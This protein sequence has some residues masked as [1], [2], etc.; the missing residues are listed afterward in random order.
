MD[1]CS[2]MGHSNRTFQKYYRSTTA[3]D[4]QAMFL[5]K[6]GRKNVTQHIDLGCPL[7]LSP[8]EVKEAEETPLVQ[9]IKRE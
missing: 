7:N 5:K 9:N 6:K 3:I 4:T 2:I 1:R 8:D